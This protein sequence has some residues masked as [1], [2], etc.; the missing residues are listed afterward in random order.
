MNEQQ[1]RDKVGVEA[2]DTDGGDGVGIVGGG[3]MNAEADA[4]ELRQSLRSWSAPRV[5]PAVVCHVGDPFD[6]DRPTYWV[7]T[8]FFTGDPFLFDSE[9][10]AVAW[11]TTYGP[12]S[13]CWSEARGFGVVS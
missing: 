12:H 3:I 9:A 13:G 4:Y 7:A 2:G 8:G 6:D 1:L 5:G 11:A 10:L